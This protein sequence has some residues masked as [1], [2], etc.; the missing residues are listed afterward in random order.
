MCTRSFETSSFLQSFLSTT[1][2]LA[3]PFGDGQLFYSFICLFF[4]F[5]FLR[6]LQLRY[7]YR[8]VQSFLNCKLQFRFW[9]NFPHWQPLSLSLSLSLSLYIY[10]Y[11]Y[12]YIC[13]CVCVCVCTFY[14]KSLNPMFFV[15]Q[16]CFRCTVADLIDREWQF[17]CNSLCKKIPL[18]WLN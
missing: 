14:L 13:V 2:P 16:N 10:I 5:S 3:R 17:L 11:I 12:I 6:A 18:G 4:N 7:I 8:N 9:L 15:F 1:K